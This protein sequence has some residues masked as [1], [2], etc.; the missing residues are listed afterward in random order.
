MIPPPRASLMLGACLYLPRTG[1]KGDLK[2]P[3][4][5]KLK[6]KKIWQLTRGLLIFT[7]TAW[8][9]F[10]VR[11]IFIPFALGFVLAYILHPLADLL[12]SCKM[13]RGAAIFLIY[14]LFASAMGLTVFYGVPAIMRDLYQLIELIPRYSASV[15]DWIRGIQLDYSRVPIPDSIRQVGDDTLKSLEGMAVGFI[16]GA[17]EGIIGLFSQA[18]NL[19]LAPVLSFYFLLDY[20]RLG[21]GILS[22]LPARYRLEV[23]AIGEEINEVIKRFIRGNILVALL[24]AILAATGMLLVGM[25]FPLLIGLLVGLTNFIPYFGAF[26]STVPV[27]LLALL[28]SKWLALYVLGIMIIIQQIEGNLISPKILGGCIGLHPLVIIFALLAG[29]KLLGFAGLLLAVPLAAVLKVVLRRVYLKL[30]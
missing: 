28:K 15:Q 29:G 12:E 10:S 24:V 1:D 8:F 14:L 27:V 17:L 9:L 2:C 6:P 7:V 25:D 4:L 26:I 23:A 30:V 13:P 19:I 16:Q 20:K 5:M 21:P 11:T 3:L 18:F 22:L